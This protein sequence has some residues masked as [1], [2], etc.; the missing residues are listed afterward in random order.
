MALVALAAVSSA[1]AFALFRN[2][3]LESKAFF[4]AA[5]ATVVTGLPDRA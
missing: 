2:A 4:T 3:W 1:I 5:K